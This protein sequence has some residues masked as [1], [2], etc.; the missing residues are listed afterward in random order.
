MQQCRLSHCSRHTVAYLRSHVHKFTERDNWT[1]NSLD[2]NPVGYLVWG[3]L[4]QMVSSHKIQDTDQL[5]RVLIDCWTQL[6]QN[7]LKRLTD[8]LPKR[9]IMVI[10][11]EGGHV[12]FRLDKPCFIVCWVKI[13]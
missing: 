7:T 12:E 3:S 9:L 6:S 5:K 8:Q 13:E 2:L 4:Q 10:K 11:V 1:P